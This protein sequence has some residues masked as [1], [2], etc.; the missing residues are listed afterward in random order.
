LCR[1]LEQAAA[2]SNDLNYY[3][4]S[5]KYF[6]S[7]PSSASGM[8]AQLVDKLLLAFILFF[9]TLRPPAKAEAVNNQFPEVISNRY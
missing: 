2:I 7:C 8:F 1:E 6:A 3:I 9:D 4:A 5:W